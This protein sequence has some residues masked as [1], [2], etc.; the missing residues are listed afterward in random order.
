MNTLQSISRI[1]LFA[2][3]GVFLVLLD[4]SFLPEFRFLKIL[5]LSLIALVLFASRVK[6]SLLIVSAGVIGFF[7]DVFSPLSF[8]GYL[9]AVTVT[10]GSVAL[11][12][13]EVFTNHSTLSDLLLLAFATVLF[14]TTIIAFGYF[15]KTFGIHTIGTVVSWEWLPFFM[16]RIAANLVGGLLTLLVS[17]RILVILRRRFLFLPHETI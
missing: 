1:L 5:D 16:S 2:I 15:T 17:R 4:I 3:V 11:L 12:T 8:G 9:I 7:L 13:R 6:A 14:H 10:I